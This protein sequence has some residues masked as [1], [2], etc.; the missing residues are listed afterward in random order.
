MAEWHALAAEIAL[1]RKAGLRPL[2][3]LRDDDAIDATPALER[4]LAL[5]VP[6]ALAVIPRD[7]RAELKARLAQAEDAAVLIHGWAHENHS[8]AG[9]KKA[10][11]GEGLALETALG[12]LS[13]SRRR[14]EDWP[15]FL[16]VLVPPW[17]RISPELVRHLPGTGIRALS[18]Y[19]E[20]SAHHAAPGVLQ[21]NT[22]VDPVDWHGTRSFI[23]DTIT[24]AALREHLQRKRRGLADPLEP[25]GILTHHLVMDAAC[26]NFLER[27]TRMPGLHW[28]MP[29]DIFAS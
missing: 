3:W 28:C 20:R 4:L 11:L 1:W 9:K 24:L 18:T 27:L 16:P 19:R 22:H 23:G 7:A 29:H 2:I 15:G 26:W 5:P 6:K 14:L 10:E 25:T 21:V 13:T 17:N 8:P 12:T